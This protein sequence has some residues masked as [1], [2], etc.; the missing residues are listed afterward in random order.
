[1]GDFGDVEPVGDGVDE[2]RIHHG[3]GYRLYYLH[4]GAALYLLLI[5]GDKASQSRDI[6]KAKVMAGD[7][8]RI[9]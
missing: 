3:P 5:G 7:L 4:R 1:M 2:M 9:S 6:Q 8:D